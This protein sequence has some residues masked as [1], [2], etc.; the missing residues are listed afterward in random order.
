LRVRKTSL[1]KSSKISV[2]VAKVHVK[3]CLAEGLLLLIG[4][5][6]W[7]TISELLSILLLGK[8]SSRTSNIS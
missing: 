6:Y 3:I 1:L 7:L 2:L 5:V 4:F 8:P